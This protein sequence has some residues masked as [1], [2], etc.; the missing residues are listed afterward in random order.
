MSKFERIPESIPD[1]L[2]VAQVIVA[3]SVSTT[4]AAEKIQ[5]FEAEFEKR[6]ALYD[7][8]SSCSEDAWSAAWMSNCE[9]VLWRHL[10]DSDLAEAEGWDSDVMPRLREL[11]EACGGW[12]V[13]IQADSVFGAG[14]AWVPLDEWRR[15]FAAH[16]A[17]EKNRTKRANRGRPT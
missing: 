11:S 6:E 16:D 15:M 2:R 10:H 9:Y 7:Y 12:V 3:T 1:A 8:M 13:W 5:K 14:P 4:Q 17:A